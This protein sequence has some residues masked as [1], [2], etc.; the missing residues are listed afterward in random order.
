MLATIV[1]ISIAMVRVLPQETSMKRLLTLAVC[2]VFFI[3]LAG[4]GEKNENKKQIK[5]ETPRGS[6]TI[7][8]NQTEKKP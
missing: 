5:I 3:F 2:L 1:A 8:I 4:C 7:E 6:T